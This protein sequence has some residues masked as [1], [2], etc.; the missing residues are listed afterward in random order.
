[1]AHSWTLTFTGT[2]ASDAVSHNEEMSSLRT[3]EYSSVGNQSK[4]A[5][6]H[7]S[8]KNPLKKELESVCK[9]HGNYPKMYI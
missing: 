6:E 4:I 8:S 7:A 5:G 2:A 1:V 9:S 3:S